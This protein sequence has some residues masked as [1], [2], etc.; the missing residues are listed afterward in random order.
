[1]VNLDKINFKKSDPENMIQKIENSSQQYRDAWSISLKYTLPSYYI[2]ANKV[3]ILGMGASGI[4]GETIKDL[5]GSKLIIETVHGYN[6]PKWTDKDTLVIA[7]SYSGDTEET[8]SG[9]FQ[10]YEKG[11]KLVAITTGGKLLLLANKYKVPTFSFDLI[12]QPREAF[13]YLFVLLL[14]VFI[15]LGHFQINSIS[16]SKAVDFLEKNSDKY[17]SSTSTANNPAK[18]IAKKLAGKTPVIYGS[19][20]LRSAAIRFKTQLNENAKNFAYYETFP[21]L[22]HNALEGINF[23]KNCFGIIALE[24]NFEEKSIIKRQNLTAEIFRKNKITYERIKFVPSE[25]EL[26]EIFSVIAFCDFVSYYFALLNGVDPTPVG[27][28]AAFKQDLQKHI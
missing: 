12:S 24:S 20:I 19:G 9:F 3:V 28:I 2:K 13:P 4:V 8:L 17:K 14:S 11:A 6:V 25:S 22:N 5:I 16:F 10:A 23:P 27:G 15:K 18:T 7:V 21:E 1:M 26:A